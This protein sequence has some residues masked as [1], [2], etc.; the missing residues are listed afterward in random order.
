MA[1]RRLLAA[2]KT[3][4]KPPVT[5][6]LL[7][8]GYYRWQTRRLPGG[9]AVILLYHHV[10]P[11]A[12]AAPATWAPFQ[13]G[14]YVERFERHMRFVRTRMTPVPLRDVVDA[15]QGRGTLPPRAVAVTFDDGYLD[16]FV[17]AYPVLRRWDIPATVFVSTAFVETSAAFWWDEVYAMLRA[18]P[19]RALEAGHEPVPGLNGSA[20]GRRPLRTPAERAG[21]AD[22]V[23]E[24]VRALS[25]GER[26]G[27]LARLRVRLQVA[28]GALA[29]A[30]PMMTWA[31]LREMSRHGVAVESHTHTH[32]ILGRTDADGVVE[33]LT[34]SKRLLE[35][36]VG[37]AVQGL[38]YPDGRPGT[39]DA[40]T[41]Q[42]ARAA[43][44]RFAC[45]AA[46]RPVAPGV[47]PYTI[48]RLPLGNTRTPAFVRDLLHVYAAAGEGSAAR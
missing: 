20:P 35:A 24:A 5:A 41:I 27:A 7:G 32:P 39:Y 11:R 2:A 38:A 42:R 34:V 10:T 47:D 26:A 8:S 15:V 12:G 1:L 25:A 40:G 31:Q 46:P 21:A 43:G 18:T 22:A 16:N 29:G 9:R 33:E 23:I 17:T 36:N 3:L 14:V 4:A 6:A 45:I 37:A 48:G 13:R 19:L 28:E 30:S 44:Y